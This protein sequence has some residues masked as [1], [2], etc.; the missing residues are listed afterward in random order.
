M[1]TPTL[2][3]EHGLDVVQPTTQRPS[4]LLLWLSIVLAVALVALAT[5]MVLDRYVFAPPP[6][7]E[8]ATITQ[9]SITAWSTGDTEAI[10]DLYA[11][12]AVFYDGP[13]TGEPM[14]EGNQAIADYVAYL[15][16]LGWEAEPAGPT[17][18]IDD[19]AVTVTNF[20]VPGDKSSVMSMLEVN[21]DGLIVRQWFE[22]LTGVEATT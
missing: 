3:K 16:G 1:Q 19:T 7:D 6:A 13:L 4:R 12:D 21:S 9:E 8:I 11:E 14:Q 5:W 15:D 20:G 2:S 18:V 10:M 17:T 22:P